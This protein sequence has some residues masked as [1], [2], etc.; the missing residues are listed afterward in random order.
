MYNYTHGIF[1]LKYNYAY[2]L[3]AYK[4]LKYNSLTRQIYKGVRL[5]TII[6]LFS[7]KIPYNY[8]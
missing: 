2:F 1:C 6:E 8:L 3:L 5:I 4:T 7:E